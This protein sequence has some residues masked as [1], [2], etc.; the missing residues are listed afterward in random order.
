MFLSA[1]FC[2]DL[3]TAAG[4]AKVLDLPPSPLKRYTRALEIT[5]II[6]GKDGGAGYLDALW[7]ICVGGWL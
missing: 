1:E 6:F 4:Y 7:G 5:M 3:L 2:A